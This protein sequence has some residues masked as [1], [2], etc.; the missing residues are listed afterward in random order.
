MTAEFV[1][2]ANTPDPVDL[3]AAADLARDLH[4][5]TTIA[6]LAFTAYGPSNYIGDFERDHPASQAV[7]RLIFD[8][9]HVAEKQSAAL[10]R[11]YVAERE[12]RNRQEAADKALAAESV[13]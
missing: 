4:Y 10:E 6:S 9:E 11:L 7:Q 1:S 12:A 3:S 13:Q 5:L 8:I 2:I